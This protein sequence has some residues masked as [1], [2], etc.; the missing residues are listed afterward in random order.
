MLISRSC[1]EQ[2]VNAYPETAFDDDNNTE[3]AVFDSFIV[4]SAPKRR[5]LSED[6]AFCHRWTKFGGKVWLLPEVV[7]QQVGPAVWGGALIQALQGTVINEEK[8]TQ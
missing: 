4:G 7:L 2:I 1:A 3:Y 5:R 8:T 6:F